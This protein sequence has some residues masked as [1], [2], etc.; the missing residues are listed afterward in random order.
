M[1]AMLLRPEVQERA[2]KEIEAVV[3]SERLP[4]FDDRN[5][6][7]FVSAIAK[8]VLRW[9]PPTPQGKFSSLSSILVH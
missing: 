5:K 4:D 3:G 8:E 2:Q 7:P 9:H 6:L 1:L